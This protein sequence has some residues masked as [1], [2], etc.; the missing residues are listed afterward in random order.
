MAME[1]Q[2]AIRQQLEERERRRREERE[3]RIKEERDEELRIE[4]EREIEIER[5][6]MELK[7]I[8]EKQD[9]E[10]KRKEA[11]EE[12]LKLAE[13]EA[14]EK[15]EKQKL[16]KQNI[17]E[18]VTEKN[19]SKDE[20]VI[21]NDIAESNSDLTCNSSEHNN[22]NNSTINEDN[23]DK[24][25]N[26]NK[27]NNKENSDTESKV[28][29]ENKNNLKTENVSPP[30]SYRSLTPR[31]QLPTYR[32]NLAFVMQPSPETLQAMQFAVLMPTMSSNF[33]QAFPFAVPV[34]VTLAN[35]SIV[36]QRTE[37]RLLTPTI[38]RTKQFCNSST[39][40]EFTD[41]NRN[42]ALDQ[43]HLNEK[44]S[45]MDLNYENRTKRGRTR[46]EDRNSSREMMEDRPKWGANR[47]PTRYLKQSEKDPLYQ[48]KKLRQKMRQIQVYREKSNQYSPHSSDE[49]QTASPVGYRRNGYV[50]KKR[51]RALWR[52]ND[53][54]MFSRNISVYQTEIIPLESDKDQIYYKSHVHK[55]CCQCL[56]GNSPRSAKA[57]D[58]QRIIADEPLKC[59]LPQSINYISNGD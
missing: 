44:F 42:E 35:E 37:N 14:R 2:E 3:R 51:T 23:Y 1:H 17:N 5:R 9:R 59:Q 56:S 10:R 33:P 57:T 11:L 58:S 53:H 28:I 7:R 6:Q 50:E 25:N 55:C 8:Q 22:S 34:P 49:S 16:L 29:S 39:Q 20:I 47:P 36:T 18:N 54:H 4:K 26:S 12:A 13:I 46:N 31:Q 41:Y 24:Y 40:T 30:N 38:Y 32:D 52:R 43:R 27:P 19:T 48:R 45:N 21:N 15:K